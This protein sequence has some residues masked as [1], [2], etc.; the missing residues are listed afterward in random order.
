MSEA[1]IQ[2]L[3]VYEHF[4]F[5]AIQAVAG[6]YRMRG[7]ISQAGALEND[8]QL[9]MAHLQKLRN[10]YTRDLAKCASKIDEYGLMRR[11]TDALQDDM[12]G[13]DKAYPAVMRV[14]LGLGQQADSAVR[15]VE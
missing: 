11:V 2:D 5:L 13:F 14:R 6:D 9:H 15:H 12:A 3:L 1:F 8:G 4:E 10:E 7:L